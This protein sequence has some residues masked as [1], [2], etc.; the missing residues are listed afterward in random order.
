[1]ATGRRGGSR[2]SWRGPWPFEVSISGGSVDPQILRSITLRFSL[3]PP[4]PL[5]ITRGDR[6]RRRILH[7]KEG[8]GQDDRLGVVVL[9]VVDDCRI[10]VE[11]DGHFALLT[12]RQALLGEAETV[13]LL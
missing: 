13:D 9:A 3:E 11:H 12:R 10:D 7:G 8:V 5:V 2:V 6:L 1:M 4:C